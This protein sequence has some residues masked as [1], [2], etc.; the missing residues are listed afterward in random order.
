VGNV[1]HDDDGRLSIV[2]TRTTR[3]SPL[4]GKSGERAR[5]RGDFSTFK[6]SPLT[7]DPLP[8]ST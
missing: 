5:V 4:P 7:P 1:E 2:I 6:K 8:M 3:L